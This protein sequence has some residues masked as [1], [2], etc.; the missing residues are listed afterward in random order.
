[1]NEI[2]TCNFIEDYA[3]DGVTE[4]AFVV[5]DIVQIAPDL[6]TKAPF[7]DVYFIHVVNNSVSSEVI[8]LNFY[9]FIFFLFILF[10]RVKI[11]RRECGV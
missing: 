1:M 5:E 6:T 10:Y 2:G 4:Y 9:F 8:S 3:D 11:T 7:G